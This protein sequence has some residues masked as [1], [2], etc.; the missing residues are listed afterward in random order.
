MIKDVLVVHNPDSAITDRHEVIRT[1]SLA[2][3]IAV[4]G[5]VETRGSSP[6]LF[7]SHKPDYEHTGQIQA[8]EKLGLLGLQGDMFLFPRSPRTMPNGLYMVRPDGQSPLDYGVAADKLAAELAMRFSGFKVR[9]LFYADG[10]FP[11][12]RSFAEISLQEGI[13]RTDS[14][15]IKFR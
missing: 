3:C 11:P 13:A 15:S 9:T 6:K 2:T 5:V 1:D 8:L 10:R 7:I 14:G 12:Q 4:G